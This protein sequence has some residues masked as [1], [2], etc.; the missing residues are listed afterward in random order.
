[1]LRY[2]KDAALAAKSDLSLIHAIEA[3]KVQS[4]AHGP[5]DEEQK[6]LQRIA[7]FQRRVGSLSAS[8]PARS[9]RH[10][11]ISSDRRRLMCS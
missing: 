5:S 3:S 10:S 11:S 9:M 8:L 6:A 2:A 4:E 7:D 1:V